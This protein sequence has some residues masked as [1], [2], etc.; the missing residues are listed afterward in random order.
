MDKT[1]RNILLAMLAVLAL[2]FIGI[3][4]EW[5]AAQHHRVEAAHAN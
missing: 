1:L 4:W 3:S 5:I 2:G